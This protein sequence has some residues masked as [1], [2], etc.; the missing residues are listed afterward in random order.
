M[1]GAT[2]DCDSPD[3]CRVIFTDSVNTYEYWIDPGRWVIAGLH[4]AGIT[5]YDAAYQYG[6]HD[7][8][9]YLRRVAVFG[10]T[11]LGSGGLEFYNIWLNGSLIPQSN[12]QPGSRGAPQYQGPYIRSD[13]YGMV[14]ALAPSGHSRRL[15]VH[16]LL[17]RR[18]Y[19]VAV[20]AGG[21]SVAGPASP[22]RPKAASA[23]HIAGLGC[24]TCDRMT[25]AYLL[26]R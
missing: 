9:Y 6:L 25:A 21:S 11:L 14:F 5:N 12:V 2:A 1:Y 16:D 20:P 17:G 7:S 19:S 26:C 10:D 8:T 22:S 15:A 3:T 23:L 13:R 18:L 24:A 4:I